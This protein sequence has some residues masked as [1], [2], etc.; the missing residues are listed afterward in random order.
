MTA[1]PTML[2]RRDRTG[3]NF[4]RAKDRLMRRCNKISKQYNSDIYVFVRWKGRHY[5]YMSTADGSLPIALDG[6][7]GNTPF[8]QIKMKEY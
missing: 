5:D 1:S 7:V 3:D 8:P 6:L 4:N 2:D